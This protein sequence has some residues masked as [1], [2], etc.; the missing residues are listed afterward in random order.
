M[1]WTPSNPATLGTSQSVLIRGVSSLAKV[2][3]QS[4]LA[5]HLILESLNLLSQHCSVDVVVGGATGCP[6]DGGVVEVRLS[7]DDGV[8]CVVVGDGYY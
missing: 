3:L 1:Q 5:L 2:N 7:E 8:K 6:G 4:S